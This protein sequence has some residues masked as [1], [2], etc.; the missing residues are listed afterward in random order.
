V[1]HVVRAGEIKYASA[2]PRHSAG[3]KRHATFDR[4]TG[5]T[6]TG[7]GLC[8][9]AAGGRVDLHVQSFEE[10]FYITDGEPTLILDGIGYPLVPG[11]CG[12]IPVAA[13]HAWLGPASGT[14]KWIEMVTPIPR[15]PGEPEDIFFLGPPP[16]HDPVPLDIRDPRS[17]YF[18]RMTDDDITL[19]KLKVGARI[20][21]PTVSASMATAL[22]A[23]SGIAVKMLVDQRLSA[24]LGTMFMVE[25]QPG[26][27]A[28]Y[29]DHPLEEAYYILQ[30]EVEA[31]A[32]G[33]IYT[34]KK[35]DVLWTAV[36]SIHAFFNRTDTTVRWL[37]TQSPQPPARYSYRFN[38]DWEYLKEKLTGKAQGAKAQG[39]KTPAAKPKAEKTLAAT[40]KAAKTK[41]AKA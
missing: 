9:L 26:G 14:A 8:S 18:F 21:S 29:H 20:D 19:D 6:H 37:E 5:S 22:L 2:Y 40:A 30:G 25:Y 36:G 27:A 39:A 12:V 17:R 7:M 16:A 35:G 15:G 11:S 31:H 1:H 4:S 32:D 33:Q 34:L 23:Y 10:Y 24:A 41:T 38:R 13:P 28:H 3:Y